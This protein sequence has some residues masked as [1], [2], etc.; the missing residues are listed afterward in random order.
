MYINLHRHMFC[1][2]RIK[3]K[4]LRLPLS[5]ANRILLKAKKRKM[6]MFEMGPRVMNNIDFFL[7]TSNGHLLW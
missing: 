4:E 7:E 1:Q 5:N 6:F 3:I 2:K